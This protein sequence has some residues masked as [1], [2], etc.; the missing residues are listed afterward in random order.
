MIGLF[1][2]AQATAVPIE[3]APRVNETVIVTCPSAPAAIPPFGDSCAAKAQAQQV[4][5]A[6]AN[7]DKAAKNE[8]AKDA[9]TKAAPK[10]E[11]DPKPTAS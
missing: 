7:S 3:P 4:D 2:M 6:V 1:L 5:Q 8:S 10:A 9:P 11:P